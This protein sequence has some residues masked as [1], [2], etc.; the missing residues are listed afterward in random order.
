MIRQ[1]ALGIA[2]SMLVL[3]SGLKIIPSGKT[4]KNKLFINQI[5]SISSPPFAHSIN[6]KTTDLEKSV[7]T[8]INRYRISQG[9]PK[10]TLNS[11]ITKQ[12]RIHSKN[13]ANGKVPFSHQGFKQRVNAISLRYKSAAENVAFNQGFSDPATEAFTSWINSPDHLINIK[14]NYNLTGIG[15]ATNSK[16]EVY[17]TQIFL[18]NQ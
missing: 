7:F 13:M 9:L 14:G 4:P 11:N 8:Q 2:L 1:S 10:L 18:R 15:V 3:A 16:G 6:F 17:L 5:L 12:A